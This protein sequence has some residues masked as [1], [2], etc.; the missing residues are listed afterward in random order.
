MEHDPVG[1]GEQQGAAGIRGREEGEAFGVEQG[2][3]VGGDAHVFGVDAAVQG[4]GGGQQ[5]V[6]GQARAVHGLLALVAGARLQGVQDRGQAVAA[7][8]EGVSG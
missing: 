4:S 6:P 1:D 3:A 5:P 7:G 2:A 8:V